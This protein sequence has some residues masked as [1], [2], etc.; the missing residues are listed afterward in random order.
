VVV[1]NL[2]GAIDEVVRGPVLVAEG[3]PD[4]DLVIHRH[5]IGDAKIAHRAADIVDVPFE[6]KF[7]CVNSEKYTC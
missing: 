1:A 3:G 7:R 5:G 4:L 2:T 6:G